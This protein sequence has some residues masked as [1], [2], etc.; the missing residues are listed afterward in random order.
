MDPKVALLSV[1]RMMLQPFFNLQRF[2]NLRCLKQLVFQRK[3]SLVVT[4]NLF[5]F[6]KLPKFFLQLIAFPQFF[7]C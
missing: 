3:I 5:E 2:F 6:W 4:L 7:I 1:K